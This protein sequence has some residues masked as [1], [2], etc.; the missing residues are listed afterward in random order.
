[1]G[2]P[3]QLYDHPA[4]REVAEFIGRAT[5]VPGI[6]DG[7]DVTIR[8]EGVERRLAAQASPSVNGRRE[9]LA[10]LRPDAL[11]FAAAGAAGAWPGVVT[12][13]RFVGALLA[14]HVRLGD[15]VEVELYSGDRSVH[16]GD[17]VALSVSREPVAVV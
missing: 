14:Y 13:R 16:E 4:S 8:I 12:G 2:T 7:S 11:T 15:G 6:Y 5:L 9:V 10:V 17:R 1:V 3:E